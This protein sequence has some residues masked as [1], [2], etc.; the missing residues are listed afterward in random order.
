M[1]VFAT[2]GLTLQPIGDRCH[3]QD[4]ASQGQDKTEQAPQVIAPLDLTPINE[5]LESIDKSIE[6][7]QPK[8][9]TADEYRRA[10]GDL[11]AQTEM[12]DWARV[13]AYVTSAS[14]IVSAFGV[15]LIILTLRQNRRSMRIGL[16]GVKRSGAA[17]RETKRIGEAQVRAY[18]ST[19]WIDI[20]IDATSHCVTVGASCSNSG[21]SP[22]RNVELC[23]KISLCGD[24]AE[25]TIQFELPLGLPDIPS[26]QS[27]SAAMTFANARLPREQ[28]GQLGAHVTT[29][30]VMSAVFANDV[31]D[32]E[33]SSF[34]QGTFF[35]PVGV[36]LDARLTNSPGNGV[37]PGWAINSFIEQ[38]RKVCTKRPTGT[39]PNRN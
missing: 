2:V 31:F 36:P 34:D 16:A 29:V 24:V 15:G 5:R 18:L 11:K 27:K 10:E 33:I 20:G 7:L 25:N 3:A 30:S 4:G 39:D 38:L 23:I 37:F 6:A 21:N 8:P 32:V 1:L 22:A 35:K 28:W 19:D 14:V 12:A 17:V 26:G 13:M 9:E